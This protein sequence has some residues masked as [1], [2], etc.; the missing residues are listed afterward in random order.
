MHLR[1]YFF[2]LTALLS[3][4]YGELNYSHSI[5]E[6]LPLEKIIVE[7]GKAVNWETIPTSN[8]M[9]VM[10]KER[11]SLEGNH[12]GF[13]MLAYLVYALCTTNELP[14]MH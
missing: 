5:V 2:L 1:Y 9:K 4:L 13:Y 10:W 6:W 7:T 11:D 12:I 3:R 8:L 14:R